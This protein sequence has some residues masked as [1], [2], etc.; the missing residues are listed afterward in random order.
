M[1]TIAKL[2][3]KGLFFASSCFAC[4]AAANAQNL[5]GKRAAGWVPSNNG[6]SQFQQPT[7]SQPTAQ[8]PA[9]RASV[10]QQ[11][12]QQPNQNLDVSQPLTQPGYENTV[13]SEQPES[14]H[15]TVTPSRSWQPGGGL[16]ARQTHVVTIEFLVTS[17]DGTETTTFN[18]DYTTHVFNEATGQWV[19][20]GNWQNDLDYHTKWMEQRGHTVTPSIVRRT[21][22]TVINRDYGGNAPTN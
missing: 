1:N 18:R 9:V 15:L 21:Q 6:Q 7:I 16:V 12:I 19:P 10:V 4:I 14:E 22:A 17:P 20:Q 5:L 2:T 8:N 13:E 3:V 11:P